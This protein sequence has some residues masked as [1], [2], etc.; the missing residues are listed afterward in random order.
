MEMVQV[1]IA[2]A[3]WPVLKGPWVG[4]KA[5]PQL[6][7]RDLSKSRG[8]VICRKDLRGS[9]DHGSSASRF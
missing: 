7:G 9:L 2:H 1:H 5:G 6:S 3:L 8:Q 4:G